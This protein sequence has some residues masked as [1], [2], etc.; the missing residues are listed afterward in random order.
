MSTTFFNV[1]TRISFFIASFFPLWGILL[2]LASYE[3]SIS[4]Y[5]YAYILII[6]TVVICISHV[7][8]FLRNLKNKSENSKQIVIKLRK[9]TTHEYVFSIIPYLLV[10]TSADMQFEKIISLLV[11]FLIIGILYVRTNMVLTNPMLLLLGFRV[12]EIIFV[13]L[14]NQ[15]N[16]KTTLL[17]TRKLPWN[18]SEMTVEE[19]SSG[20]H[21]EYSR[22]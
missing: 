6:L 14:H 4:E 13:E 20:I 17:L 19:I 7:K 22:S 3:Y 15:D 10:L 8:I 16:E 5:W 18:G 12:F 1:L 11:V 2:Y 9:E 21:M